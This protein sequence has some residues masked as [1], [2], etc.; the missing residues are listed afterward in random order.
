MALPGKDA[1]ENAGTGKRKPAVRGA[2]RC[3]RRPAAIARPA[4]TPEDHAH[5]KL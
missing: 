5:W 1:S 3:Y 4:A 2:G